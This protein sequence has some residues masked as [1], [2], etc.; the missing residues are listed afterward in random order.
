MEKAKMARPSRSQ[1]NQMFSDMQADVTTRTLT[2]PV[3][4]LANKQKRYKRQVL[5]RQ[6]TTLIGQEHAFQTRWKD[7]R[8]M[9]VPTLLFPASPSL[10][11][12]LNVE[13]DALPGLNQ[14]TSCMTLARSRHAS[15]VL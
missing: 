12:R 11:L 3:A 14:R 7:S 1:G 9:F 13:I 6:I 15:K 4:L 8:E 2:S 10:R 5:L